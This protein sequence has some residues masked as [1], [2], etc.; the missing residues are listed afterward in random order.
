MCDKPT[1]SNSELFSSWEAEVL[2]AYKE[3]ERASRRS[4]EISA[5][6][7]EKLSALDSASIAIAASAIIAITVKPELNSSLFFRQIVHV[8]I[9][10][11]LL[12]WASLIF[13]VLHNF[14][15]ARIAAL[16]ASY[17]GLDFLITNMR[18]GMA[19]VRDNVTSS[20]QVGES[21]GGSTIKEPKTDSQ[22]A[23]N[24]ALTY[25][26]SRL[27]FDNF[28][29]CRIHSRSIFPAPIVVKEGTSKIFYPRF[30]L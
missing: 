28:V 21:N 12:L 5:S 17:S 9:V 2:V 27:L 24:P 30:R 18:S 1:G 10:I 23:A 6:F 22:M 3:V 25:E 26:L 13:T 8:L 29:P 4:L 11:V 7:F 19:I 20:R 14:L 16:E 15:F